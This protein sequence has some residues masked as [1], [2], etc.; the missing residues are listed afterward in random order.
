MNT[1]SWLLYAADAAGSLK[2]V[3]GAFSIMSAV[4]IVLAFG[5]AVISGA[6]GEME[7]DDDTRRFSR[8]MRDVIKSVLPFI[9]IST[10]IWAALPSS[11]TIYVIAASEVGEQIIASP[12]AAE[13]MG[14]VKAIIK[15]RLKE[16]LAGSE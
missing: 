3:L 9:V 11:Q 16:E 12:D 2:A 10:A 8:S 6:I 1:L 13:M 14:D 15:K 7:D 5:A 4:A